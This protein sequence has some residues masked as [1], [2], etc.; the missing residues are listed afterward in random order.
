MTVQQLIR[1]PLTITVTTTTI[2]TADMTKHLRRGVVIDEA[3]IDAVEAAKKSLYTLMGIRTTGP[4]RRSKT[5][6]SNSIGASRIIP[7]APRVCDRNMPRNEIV[8]RMPSHSGIFCLV[9]FLCVS[10]Y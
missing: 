9:F 4:F 5:W 3:V 7:C 10:F 2:Q 6:S 1:V 8:R